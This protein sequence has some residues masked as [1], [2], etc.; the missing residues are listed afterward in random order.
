MKLP[1]RDPAAEKSFHPEESA[2]LEIIS[3]APA[4]PR[5]APPL[6]F[7]HGAWHGAWCWDEGFLDYFAERGFAAHALSLRAHGAS[8]GKL[9]T[10][11]IRDYV[12]DVAR[13]VATLPSAPVLVGH[14]MGGFVVQK[15]LETHSAPAAVLLASVPP[16]GARGIAIRA[17]RG[18]PLDVLK[19]NLTLSLRPLISDVGRARRLL[20]SEAAPEETVRRSFSRLQDE[21]WFAYLDTLLFDLVR[22]E[23][24]TAPIIVMGG[25]DDAMVRP[26]EVI[27]TAKAYR[28]KPT[29]LAGVAH[30]MMLD[31]GWRRVAGAMARELERYFPNVRRS[32]PP[33]SNAA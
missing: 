2:A 24:V 23:R 8:P 20:F 3:K 4:A 16:R 26:A 5:P 28:V 31:L 19:C 18:Q 22:S 17:T 1:S 33:Q 30:D 27:A 29:I 15:Y 21:A 25:G 14:S 12:E 7:V 6:L 13:A 32:P 9:R 10:T 11:R